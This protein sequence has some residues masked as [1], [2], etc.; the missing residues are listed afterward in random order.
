MVGGLGIKVKTNK[1]I[2]LLLV[3]FIGRAYYELARDHG[4]NKWLFLL[5]GIAVYYVSH[6]LFAFLIIFILQIS[7]PTTLYQLSEFVIMLMAL[8]FSIGVTWGLLQ[9]LK[10]NWKDF[11]VIKNSD[12]LDDL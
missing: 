7:S 11:V 2:A 5:V 8:P 4:K 3:Y 9:I 6:Y 10:K 1:M 12:I